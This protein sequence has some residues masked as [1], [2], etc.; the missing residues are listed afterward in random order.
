MGKLHFSEKDYSH[1][2]GRVLGCV[3]T[4]GLSMQVDAI[5]YDIGITISELNCKNNR[6]VCL[7]NPKVDPAVRFKSL[8]Q[9]NQ[10]LIMK[11][12]NCIFFIVVR[13]ISQGK[14]YITRLIS[15]IDNIVRVRNP[16]FTTVSTHNGIVPDK[17]L[18]S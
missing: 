8:S 11:E 2:E 13:L 5:D 6:F 15:L 16:I 12:Y 18:F 3:D 10:Y 7:R 1:L 9:Q 14:I 4:S 17:C